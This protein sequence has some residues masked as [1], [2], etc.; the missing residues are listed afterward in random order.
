MKKLDGLIGKYVHLKETID[1]LETAQEI[2]FDEETVARINLYKEE[3]EE[4]RQEIIKLKEL[5]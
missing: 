2:A 3:L 4:M 5:N 1:M